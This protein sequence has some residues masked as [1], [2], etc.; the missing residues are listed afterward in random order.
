MRPY[1]SMRD[2]SPVFRSCIL[3]VYGVVM[4]LYS[5]EEEVEKEVITESAI[6]TSSIDVVLF[7]ALDLR[8]HISR[9]ECLHRGKRNHTHKIWK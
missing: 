9:M 6:S 1:R 2:L 8:R 5:R 3:F 4:V 7:E